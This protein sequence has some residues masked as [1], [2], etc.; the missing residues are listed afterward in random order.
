MYFKLTSG[1][2]IHLSAEYRD[3]LGAS[4]MPIPSRI[5]LGVEAN[6]AGKI[7]LR[8]GINAGWLTWGVGLT[9]RK[10]ALHFGFYSEERGTGFLSEGDP[11][12][13]LQWEARV[14]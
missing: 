12:W 13:F 4:G 7:Q 1:G 2:S 14:F 6:I 9:G 11:R 8:G 3:I 10:S 5:G